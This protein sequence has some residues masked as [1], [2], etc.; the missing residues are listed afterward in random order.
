M[1]PVSYITDRQR[2]LDLYPI[3]LVDSLPVPVLKSIHDKWGIG[4]YPRGIAAEIAV[5]HGI[6]L[7][8]NA[9][10]DVVREAE[11]RER[12]CAEM[13]AE[14]RGKLLNWPAVAVRRTA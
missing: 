10:C 6:H 2:R 9:V 4:K 1:R 11:R 3:D 5:E 8:D 14:R 12:H 13:R 7:G